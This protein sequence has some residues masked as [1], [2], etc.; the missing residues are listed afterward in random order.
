MDYVYIILTLDEYPNIEVERESISEHKI[1]NITRYEVRIT[2]INGDCLCKTI[3][4]EKIQI[5]EL[6]DDLCQVNL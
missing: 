4:E 6:I 2:G 5:Y 1:G 3:N